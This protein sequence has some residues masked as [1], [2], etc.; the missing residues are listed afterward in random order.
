[1][2]SHTL[3]EYPFRGLVDR[4]FTYDIALK[5]GLSL[6]MTPRRR[7]GGAGSEA[8]LAE[9]GALVEGTLAEF[10]KSV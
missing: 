10:Q 8:H 1:M 5:V 4:D 2:F 3:R 6:G 9:I 7:D